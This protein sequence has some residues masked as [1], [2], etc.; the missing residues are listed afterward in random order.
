V[1]E[2][3]QRFALDE[4]REALGVEPAVRL[5]ECDARR[6]ESVKTVLVTLTE[7]VL[8]QRLAGASW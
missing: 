8:A 7:E 5:V 6:R 1:F 2:P 4:V 3:A